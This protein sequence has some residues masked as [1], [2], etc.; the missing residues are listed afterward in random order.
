MDYENEALVQ[1]N[2]LTEKQY[3]D[4]L[5][6][7]QKIPSYRSMISGKVARLCYEF[8]EDTG[9][10]VTETIHVKK[11]DIDFRTRILT[12]TYPKTET[13]CSCSIWKNR[14]EYSRVRILESAKIDC[15][16]CHG[17]GKWKKAQY[18]TIT[19]RIV[20][21]LLEYSNTLKNDELLFPISRQSLWVWADKA[22]QNAGI[23]IFQKKEERLIIGMFVHFFR[24]LCSKRVKSDAKDD[25]FRDELVACKLRH[26][27]QVMADR[28]TKI[29]INYLLSW[30]TKTYSKN[31][32]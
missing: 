10:R 15:N 20:P 1:A 11:R 30:E 4:F 29:D 3:Q 8:M 19:P 18:T 25:R 13:K 9:C 6:E 14:D 28:Y 22:G 2:D 16:N 17:K 26:A 32:L 23:N 7:V 24:A 31:S 5:S 27:Y 12:V 21:K